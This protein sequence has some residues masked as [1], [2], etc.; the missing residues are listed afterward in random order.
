MVTQE[1]FRLLNL[2]NQNTLG[3]L[4]YKILAIAKTKRECFG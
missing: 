3:K 4:S 1:Q 2:K